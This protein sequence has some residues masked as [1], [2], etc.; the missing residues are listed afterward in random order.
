[1][2]HILKIDRQID[3][4]MYVPGLVDI[5]WWTGAELNGGVGIVSH[6]PRHLKRQIV[7]IYTYIDRQILVYTYV[8]V[9]NTLQ[10]V[11][12][13]QMTG[14]Q[15]YIFLSMRPYIC[16]QYATPCSPISI[17]QPTVSILQPPTSLHFPFSIVSS[18]HL[19]SP[20]SFLQFLISSIQSILKQPSLS[21][22]VQHSTSSI[23]P[24][25]YSLQPTVFSL[26]SPVLSLH[27][28][29]SILHSPAPSQSNIKLCCTWQIFL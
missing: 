25:V 14:P 17:L 10:L 28:P 15:L 22:S 2:P 20:G 4:Y 8:D 9:Y 26:Q 19:Q 12:I 16:R 29:V 18:L 1:M 21:S 27:S 23:Q 11:I 13:H 5:K 6:I 3:R 7:Q 24:S